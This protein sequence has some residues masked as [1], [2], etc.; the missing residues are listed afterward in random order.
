MSSMNEGIAEIAM[1]L[2]RHGRLEE[3]RTRYEFILECQGADAQATFMLGII[4]YRLSRFRQALAWF[5]ATIRIRPDFAEAHS[6]RGLALLAMDNVEAAISGFDKAVALNPRYAEAWHNRGI[7]CHRH[8]RFD[9]AD[10]SFDKAIDIRPDFAPAYAGKGDTL[11]TIR[12]FGPAI[13]CYDKVISIHSGIPEIWMNRGIALQE[14]ERFDDALNSYEQAI[15]LAPDAPQPHYNRGKSFQE[16]NKL[17][18]A[19]DCYDRAIAIR[20]DYAEARLNKSFALL[21]DGNF[22]EGLELYEWRWKTA[23]NAPL[24]RSFTR[25]PWLGNE[26]PAGKTL[27]IHAEQGFG[28]TI[29]FSRYAKCLADMGATVIMQVQPELAGVL[30]DLEGV[31]QLVSMSTP[32]PPFDLHCPMLS[33]P[34][35]CKTEIQT[36]PAAAKYISAPHDNLAKWRQRLG[37]HDGTLR[38]G[39]AW[40]GNPLPINGR[41]RTIPLAQLLGRL[42]GGLR[43]FSLQKEL[44]PSDLPAMETCGSNITHF[45]DELEDF[46]DTAALCELMDLVVSIDTGIAHLSAALGKATWVLLPFSPDWRWLLGRD[47]SPWYPMATL[48]RQTSRGNWNDVLEVVATRLEQFRQLHR[49]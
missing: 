18:D 17:Q 7:A 8:R 10:A 13:S 5:D 46:G 43:Y 9:A 23:T 1:E 4:E 39:L 24:Q 38:I 34:L 49:Y 33:L 25:H 6:N 44:W 12:Q 30:R 45:G 31:S 15:A 47:D 37:S 3:A 14:L 26:S 20:P 32:P 11:L 2:Y 27:L 42:P 29:Q 19:I 36:I 41:K 28:D 35:A 21:L 48:F 22:N 16:L 40:S